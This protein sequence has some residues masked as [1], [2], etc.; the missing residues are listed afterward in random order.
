MES[1][2]RDVTFDIMKGIG[3]LLMLVGHLHGIGYARQIIY[4]FHMP[5]FFLVAGYFTK[6]YRCESGKIVVYNY[7]R[8][9]VRPVIFTYALLF[10]Y[11]LGLSIVKQDSSIV[12]PQIIRMFWVSGEPISTKWGLISVGVIWFVVALFWAKMGLYYLSRWPKYVLPISF[13]VSIS[14]LLFHHHVT[15]LLPWCILQGF[16]AFSFVAVGYWEKNHGFPMWI[17]ILSVVMW[18]IA[19]IFSGIEM[20]SC[21]MKCYPLDFIGACGGTEL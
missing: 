14:A 5:M 18:P 8:R 7:F 16:M 10:L 3:I 9:L 17:K 12:M 19:I 21:E 1:S 20:Y 11:L 2:S 4:S 6:G 13:V 15:K